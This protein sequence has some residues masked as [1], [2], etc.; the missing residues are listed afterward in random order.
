MLTVLRMKKGI[1]QLL[2]I[3]LLIKIISAA[4]MSPSDL[5]NNVNPQDLL[6]IVLFVV[7]FAILHNLVFSRVFNG[8]TA[9]STIVAGCISLL[10]IWGINSLNFDIS[11]LFYSFGLTES[12]I[13]FISIVIFF[14]ILGYFAIKKK[15]RYL[16]TVLGLVAMLSAILSDFWYAENTV[17]TIGTI[18]FLIGLWRIWKI[19]QK[20]RA[21]N[22][23]IYGEGAIARSKGWA[24]RKY[25]R[26]QGYRDERAQQKYNLKLEKREIKLRKE[27]AQKLTKQVE[28]TQK[29]EMKKMRK[30]VN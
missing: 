1:L 15:L 4:T 2:F 16:I 8:N 3:P 6:L 7:F 20:K 29:K 28:K 14:M 9:L 22:R 5:L 21:I 27:E 23:G 18:L 30:Y 12:M 11:N 25:G 19:G 26:W 17:F 13:Y 24:K 10:S